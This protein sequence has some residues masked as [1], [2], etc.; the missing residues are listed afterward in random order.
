[1]RA[2]LERACRR[3]Y[4]CV[5]PLVWVEDDDNNN[6]NNKNNNGDDDDNDNNNNNNKSS[7]D[8]DHDNNNNY[9]YD[10]YYG[11]FEVFPSLTVLW[12]QR[13]LPPK[14]TRDF[15]TVGDLG[16]GDLSDS[17]VN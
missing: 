9:Y 4:A 6:N 7:N 8:H 5:Y 11:L 15:A 2:L 3:A 10:R 13:R 16:I 17:L 14:L 1:M 12:N